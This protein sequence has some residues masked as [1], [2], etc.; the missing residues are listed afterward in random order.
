MA[1]KKLIKNVRVFDGRSD[2]LTEHVAV[3]PLSL[4]MGI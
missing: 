4:D 3:K 2:I 1:D